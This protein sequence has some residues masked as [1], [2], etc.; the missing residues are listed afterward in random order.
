MQP[1]DHSVLLERIKEVLANETIR[2]VVAEDYTRFFQQLGVAPFMAS[3]LANDTL[4]CLERPG[5]DLRRTEHEIYR[6]LRAM[7]AETKYIGAATVGDSFADM[8]QRRAKAFSG[9][10]M[11]RMMDMK[12]GSVANISPHHER[13]VSNRN[14]L[15]VTE[16]E[17]T[18]GLSGSFSAAVLN[19]V[20]HHEA[21]E[22]ADEILRSVSSK[23]T[24]RLVVLENTTVGKTP[25]EQAQD[26]AVQFMH[27][28]L[29]HR[30]LQDPATHDTPLPGNYD[31]AEGWTQRIEEA[32]WR[33][34][35]RESHFMEPHHT[36]LVFEKD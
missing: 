9:Q 21:P 6:N 8:L 14:D 34:N 26:R 31:T 19:N 22:R 27:E 4:L 24:D 16:S 12:G 29:F 7:P 11:V 35:Y 10:I 30:L 20:L 18:D 2:Q 25:D 1:Q 3:A 32:G 36:V 23:V 13:L 33:L 5:W 28:Y 15:K 17:N